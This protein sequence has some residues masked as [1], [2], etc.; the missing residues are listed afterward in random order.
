MAKRNK[1][2]SKASKTSAKHSRQN[3]QT[4]ISQEPPNDFSLLRVSESPIETLKYI[5]P[6]SAENLREEIIDSISQIYNEY[7]ND[8]IART[9]KRLTSKNPLEQ[10]Q[11]YNLVVDRAFR[12]KLKE[13][14]KQL[15]DSEGTRELHNSLY[16]S[17]HSFVDA[18]N[19]QLAELMGKSKM[20]QAICLA[21]GYHTLQNASVEIGKIVSRMFEDP[22]IT[23]ENVNKLV[24]YEKV[25]KNS[26]SNIEYVKSQ[27]SRHFVVPLISKMEKDSKL[28][29]STLT[30]ATLTTISTRDYIPE[31]GALYNMFSDDSSSD[32][33]EDSQGEPLHNMSLDEL[34]KYI[35]GEPINSKK[36]NPQNRISKAST[37]ATSKSPNRENAENT[38][39]DKEIEDFKKRLEMCNLLPYRIK[40]KLTQD[41]LN[42]LKDKIEQLKDKFHQ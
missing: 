8:Y 21:E 19:D 28:A 2:R 29:S 6:E 27:D 31:P 20:L 1:Q 14:L 7:L 42:S 9:K 4:L 18:I 25:V 22:A 26:T 38:S 12:K 40:P 33:E 10:R 32:Y 34:V 35:N 41:Y 39:F 37:A 16:E 3:S 36:R 11:S 5:N 24:F 17:V 15:I 23:F 13:E 30:S